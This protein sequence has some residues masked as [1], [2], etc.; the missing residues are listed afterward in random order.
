ML[1]DPY[2][3]RENVINRKDYRFRSW[4]SMMSKLY[5]SEYEGLAEIVAEY[6]LVI[7]DIGA[8]HDPSKFG[9]SKLLEIMQRREFMW[10]VFTSNMTMEQIATLDTRIASRFLRNGCKVIEMPIQDFN[11]KD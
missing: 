7:D 9:V 10:T 11:L 3:I 8:A 6:L 2:I 4:A 1:G 5:A